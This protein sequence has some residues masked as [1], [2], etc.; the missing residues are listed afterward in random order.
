VSVN[1][2]STPSSSSALGSGEYKRTRDK[3]ALYIATV[4]EGRS[5]LDASIYGSIYG[6]PVTFAKCFSSSLIRDYQWS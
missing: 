5:P 3:G 4:Y 2:R 6:S 1:I